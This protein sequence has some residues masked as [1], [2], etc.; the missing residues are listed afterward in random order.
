MRVIINESNKYE[1]PAGV[2]DNTAPAAGLR[3]RHD[4]CA[5]DVEPQAAA[6]DD[7]I[8]KVGDQTI[9]FSEINT[10]LNSS[11]I[12]GLS[13]PALGT[14]QRDTARIILLDRFVSANLLYLDALKQGVDKDPGYQRRSTAFP[15][16]SWPVSIGSITRQEHSGKR[17]RSTSL[18]QGERGA[19]YGTD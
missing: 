11:A 1:S 18:F 4:G 16:R 9:T 10:A 2:Y 17:R 8:A 15:M 7:V 3:D 6:V 19:G 5:A 14:P 12:V 13:I